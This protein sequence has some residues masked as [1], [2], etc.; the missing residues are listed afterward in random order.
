MKPSGT[1]GDFIIGES[2]IGQVPVTF[3]FNTTLISQYANSPILYTL[4]ENFN[5]YIDQSKDIDAFFSMFF[6]VDSAYGVGLDV[7]GRIVGVSRVIP[8]IST[9]GFFS[10]AGTN[11]NGEFGQ[12]PFYSGQALTENFELSDDAF[13]TL[14]F[15]KSFANISNNSI[16]SINQ[17][18]LLLFPNRGVC[19]VQDNEDMTITYKFLFSLTL[20]E[21]S[22]VVNSGVLPR[23]SG[24]SVSYSY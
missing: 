22:I 24:V 17:L 4:I 21:Q 18:L 1:I 13:R 20:V 16:A 19:Y 10:F 9:A 3:D 8:V 11:P 14:I 15:A 5:L 23:T 6:S 2:P 12:N 7:L